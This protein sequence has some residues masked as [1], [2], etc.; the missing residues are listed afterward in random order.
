MS[1]PTVLAGVDPTWWAEGQASPDPALVSRARVSALG[2]RVLASWLAAGPGAALLG[3]TPEREVGTV[4]VRWPREKLAPFVR[5]LGI[6][7]MAP[8]IRAEIGRDAVR[9]L[10]QSL[11]NSYLLAL[12]RTVWDGKVAPGSLPAMAAALRT[13]LPADGQGPE[14]LYVLFDRQGRSE[15]RAWGARHDR[16]L[17]EWIALLYP[18]EPD[19]PALLPA[20]QV[21]L[22]HEHHL[23]RER[24]AAS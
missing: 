8:A 21:Q 13:A 3:P 15:L 17:G 19:L 11:G 16:A 12:D 6:L 14:T 2:E 20:G 9:R 7:A 23:A 5:D 18:R 22:L 4:A 24:G 1:L 10:K